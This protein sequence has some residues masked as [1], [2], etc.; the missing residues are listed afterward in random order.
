[1]QKWEIKDA[2]RDLKKVLTACSETP[3]LVYEHGKP[4]GA[5]ID[6]L[7]FQELMRLRS[8]Q[9]RPTITELLQE[10]SEIQ[11]E[12]PIVL[13]IPARTNRSNALVED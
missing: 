5:I 4:L 7:L 12:T 9:K 11:A 6:I 13:E 2:E 3:Q 10:L 1:M 8:K